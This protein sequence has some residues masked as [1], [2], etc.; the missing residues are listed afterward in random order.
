MK[1]KDLTKEEDI[2]NALKRAEFVKREIEA[3]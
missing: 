3:L 1:N 2:K